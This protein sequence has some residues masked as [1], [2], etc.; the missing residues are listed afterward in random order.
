MQDNIKEQLKKWCDKNSTSGCYVHYYDCDFTDVCL[1]GNFDLEDLADE[2]LKSQRD[3]LVEKIENIEF[4]RNNVS[5]VLMKN[6]IINLI[7]ED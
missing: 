3:S 5:R 4:D 2:L 1:D 7:K 6:E